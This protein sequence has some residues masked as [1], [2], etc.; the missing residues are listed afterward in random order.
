MGSHV[1]VLVPHV[2]LQPGGASAPQ[3]GRDRGVKKV[4]VTLKEAELQ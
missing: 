1:I 2:N 3:E 4:E